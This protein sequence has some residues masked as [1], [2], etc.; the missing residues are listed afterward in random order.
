MV[1]L[2]LVLVTVLA[3]MY[4]SVDVFF[5][6]FLFTCIV[7]ESCVVSAGTYIQLKLNT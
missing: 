5:I 6:S 4:Y 2:L 7:D 3:C 1:V